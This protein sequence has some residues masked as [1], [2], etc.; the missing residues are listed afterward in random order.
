[1]HLHVRASQVKMLE[2]CLLLEPQWQWA[3]ALL[4]P[5]WPDEWLERLSIARG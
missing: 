4:E 3:D 1:V 5:Q 2:R